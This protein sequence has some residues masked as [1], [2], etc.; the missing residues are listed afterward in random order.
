MLTG[1]LLQWRPSNFIIICV[2]LNEKI[3]TILPAPM[4][5]WVPEP[6]IWTTKIPITN[7]IRQFIGGDIS[8]Y[9]IHRY[10]N[11][12]IYIYL[13]LRRS[14]KDDNCKYILYKFT[15]YEGIKNQNIPKSR[16]KKARKINFKPKRDVEPYFASSN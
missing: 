10:E 3:S 11:Y 4:V 14:L 13:L 2:A 8:S 16:N 1:N 5:I 7:S 6:P 15:T 12:V 9:L